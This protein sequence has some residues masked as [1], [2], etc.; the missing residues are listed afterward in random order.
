[1]PAGSSLTL[2]TTLRLAP[3]RPLGDWFGVKNFYRVFLTAALC[4]IGLNSASAE[5]TWLTDFA[6]AQSEAKAGD[7]LLLLDFTGSDWCIWCRRLQAEVFSQPEFEE[8]AKK[9]LVLM[10]VDFPRAKP[11]STEVRKQ[12]ATLAQKFEV[13]GFPSIV[14]LNGDGKQV[15][16]LG[17]V[18]GGPGAFIRELAKVPKS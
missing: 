5:A 18:P 14:I 9:N 17:Y 3:G 1:L 11:L 16:L 2:Q 6:K 8:Y 15:G 4:A 7:K 10:T 12:N 13:E